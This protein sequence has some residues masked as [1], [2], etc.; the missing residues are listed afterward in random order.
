MNQTVQKVFYIK[1]SDLRKQIRDV[2]DKLSPKEAKN[3]Q[4]CEYSF[5]FEEGKERLAVK[6]F[7]SG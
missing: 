5:R 2:L 3:E 1:D 4:Y 6:Q 7:A